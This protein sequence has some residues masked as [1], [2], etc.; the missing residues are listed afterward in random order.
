MSTVDAVCCSARPLGRGAC[1][2]VCLLGPMSSFFHPPNI[3]EGEEW[4]SRAVHDQLIESPGGGLEA[5]VGLC[6]SQGGK[7][8][9]ASTS[10]SCKRIARKHKKTNRT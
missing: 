4:T 7:K 1:N 6:R 5:Q 10:G 3:R 8:A 2:I 9:M